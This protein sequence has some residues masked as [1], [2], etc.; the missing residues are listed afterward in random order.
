[1]HCAEVSVAAI[2]VERERRLPLQGAVNFRDLGGYPGRDGRRIRWGRIFRSDSLAELTDA[3]LQ[4]LTSLGLRTIC[5]LRADSER[6]H[7]P[8]RGLH[9]APVTI[10]AINI[11]PHGGDQL[12]ADTR[13]GTVSVVEI[14]RRVREIYRRFVTDQVAT[15]SRLLHL[16][17]TGPLPLLVH[18]T[19]GRDRTG[20]ASALIL[21]ALGVSRKTIARDYALSNQYRRDLTFQIGG[22]VSP[23]V[24][25]ALTQAHPDYLAAAF[26]AIDDGWGSDD[27]YLRNG[28]GFSGEKRQALQE[29][30]LQ[31]AGNT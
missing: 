1:M 21:M 19:S 30:L 6:A 25:T 7:K 10:H 27:A 20:F 26:K 12:L 9:G 24:M 5:D 14:E 28:L 15:F 8:N 3:D 23:E 2:S 4:V 18:C 17:D 16:F 29:L 31:P 13:L 11:M 22:V